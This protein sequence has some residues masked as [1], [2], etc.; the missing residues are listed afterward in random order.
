MTLGDVISANWYDLK[1]AFFLILGLLWFRAL[2]G[3]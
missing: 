1:V 2:R 3:S